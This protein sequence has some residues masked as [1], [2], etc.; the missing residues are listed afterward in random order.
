MQSQLHTHVQADSV[1]AGG[2]RSFSPLQPTV[3][4]VQGCAAAGA[5]TRPRRSLMPIRRYTL[6][7]ITPP[8]SLA[9]RVT[10]MASDYHRRIGEKAAHSK[11]CS[12]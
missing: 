9:F 7:A 11:V 6:T 8:M 4:H 10:M 2:G 3:L 1:G 12:G 5:T